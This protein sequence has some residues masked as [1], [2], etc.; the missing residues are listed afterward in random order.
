MGVR[1]LKVTSKD[2]E[3]ASGKLT[4]LTGIDALVQIIRNRLT[5]WAGEN[6]CM[7]DSGIDYIGL[8]NLDKNISIEKRAR[9]I[10]RDAILADARIVKLKTLTISFNNS[11]RKLAVEFS[12][13]TTSGLMADTIEV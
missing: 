3:F 5:M 1:T 11:T 6:F 9:K 13:E 8:H 4:Q 7:P 2:L 12:A 10:F